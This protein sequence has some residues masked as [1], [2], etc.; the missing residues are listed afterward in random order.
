MFNVGRFDPK[1][2]TKQPQKLSAKKKSKHET[3][4]KKSKPDKEEEA[5]PPP[6]RPREEEE[7]QESYVIAPEAEGPITQTPRKRQ[8]DRIEEEAFDDLE[9]SATT[10]D[11]PGK[12][13]QKAPQH[14][15]EEIMLRALRMSNLPLQEAANTWNLPPFLVDNLKQE[16]VEQFFPIQALVIPDILASEKYSYI[17]AQ[18][19]CVSSPTGSGKTLAFVLPVLNALA[20]RKIKRLRAL[21]VLPSRDLGKERNRIMC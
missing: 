21:V 9:I 11:D 3:R 7:P 20:G 10:T 13:D 14:I 2:E 5:A 12:S 16:G 8:H 1:Q 19:I 15:D 6:K 18:D 4:K 17:R